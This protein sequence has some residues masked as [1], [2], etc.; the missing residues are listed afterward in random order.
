MTVLRRRFALACLLHATVI[1]AGYMSLPP[2][3]ASMVKEGWSVLALQQAWAAIPLGSAP[4]ALIA[5]SA[6]RRFGAP[7]V[8]TWSSIAASA[9]IALRAL[10]D[11][12]VPFSAALAVYGFM[13]GV[14][15]AT[16]TVE[17]GR[18]VSA[19]R[20][21]VAQA[22][23]FG[24]YA[25]GA[26]L[27]VGL[28][29]LSVQLLG[30][31]AVCWAVSAIGFLLAMSS[32]RSPPVVPADEA[33]LGRASTWENKL[34]S[35]RYSAAYAAYV[36]GYLALAGLLPYQLEKWGWAPELASLSLA[37]T[38]AAF[39]IGACLWTVLTDALGG[40]LIV[41]AITMILSGLSTAL[42]VLF[43]RG[44][45]N[46]VAWSVIAAVGFFGGGMA[47]FFPLLLADVRL[48]SLNGA[49]SVGHA[50]AASYLGGAVLPFALAGLSATRPDG[51]IALFGL[52]IAAAGLLLP[53]PASAAAAT[54]G[55]LAKSSSCKRDHV[56]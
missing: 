43:A 33:V 7:A 19:R 55:T 21:G 29:G 47:V 16:L 2:M 3:F 35:L 36:G 37:M 4:G 18:S 5:A 41:F 22:L 12:V 44:E 11:G 34:T 10:S 54:S 38:T 42:I 52:S 25:I 23:F 51:A 39:L 24:S 8:I 26:A 46:P 14:L 1:G 27:A 48:G 40:R 31:R 17:V 45:S 9:A 15:L 30:W 53:R 56:A 13:T 6:I 50:T 20:A 32:W 28:A 49:P